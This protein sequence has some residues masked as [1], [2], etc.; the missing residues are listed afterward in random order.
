MLEFNQYEKSDK[1]PLIIYS[2]L[3]CVIEKIDSCKN[4]PENS[5]TTKLSKHDPSD[6]SITTT[7]SFRSFKNKHHVCRGKDCMKKFSEF[8]KGVHN[9][10]F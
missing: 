3:E 8:L 10:Y 6:F 9:S 1:A 5:S 4:N 2:D 7:F